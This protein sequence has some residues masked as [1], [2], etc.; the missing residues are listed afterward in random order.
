[1]RPT[2][3]AD[4]IVVGG[5]PAGLLVAQTLADSGCSVVVLEAGPRL[6]R[7][8]KTPEPDRRMWPYRWTGP[9]FDWYRVRALGGRSLLWGGW[10]YRFP[11][12]ALERAGWPYGVEQLVP[13][14]DA[15]EALLRVRTGKLDGRYARLASRL[16]LSVLPKRG[17]VRGKGPWTP[18]HLQVA[19]RARVHA[20]A[21]RV[22][23]TA[24]R[25]QAVE[26]VDLRTERI[27]RLRARAFVLAASPIETARILVSSELGDGGR[28]IGSG[29]VDHMVASYV[30]V[31]PRPPPPP[32]GRGPF[33]GCA[34]VESFVNAGRG[35]ERAYRGGFSIELSGP[36][37]LS[38][39][40]LE[41]MVAS[42]DV[43]RHCATLVHAVGEVFPDAGRRVELDTEVRDPIGRPVP[44]ITYGWTA[45]DEARAGDM[46]TACKSLAEALAVPGSR[47]VPFVD[48]LQPGAGHEA[49]TCS[50]GARDESA[51]DEWGRLR[52]LRNVWVADASVMP[53]AGDRHP[54]LTLL[55]HAL[56]VAWSLRR[57]LRR[58]GG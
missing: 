51:C 27:E 38:E 20:L 32:R 30:L 8:A 40:G 22:E 19:R 17:A 29:L 58:T 57:W 56:R 15:V 48:P 16:R 47:L 9:S 49:G 2:G 53:T 11:A 42:D 33:P 5:G 34:L 13:A 7:G 45:E 52:A 35:T 37:A 4:A 36:V 26:V 21:V 25:V 23:H 44:R 54:T 46:K 14:Y 24:R 3:I 39:I 18:V 50:F 10:A 55:A 28:E 31:E 12:R 6:A 1:M 43:E 41:R